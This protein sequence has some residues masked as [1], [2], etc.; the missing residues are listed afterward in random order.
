MKEKE[1]MLW[2]WKRGRKD[3]MKKKKKKYKLKNRKKSGGKIQSKMERIR[4]RKRVNISNK[5]Q[6]TGN[7]K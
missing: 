7:A 6:K 1:G 3:E 2:A 5:E 4:N